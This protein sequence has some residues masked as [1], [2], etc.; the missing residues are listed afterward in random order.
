MPLNFTRTAFLFVC[1]VAVGAAAV[2]VATAP[3][4]VRQRRDTARAVCAESGGQWVMV[5]DIE[6]CRRTTD[7]L[8][9]I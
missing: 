7:P 6:V 5:D 1:V 4:R 3:D 9:K 8:R 2:R